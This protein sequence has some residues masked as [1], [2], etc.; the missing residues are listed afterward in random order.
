MSF[1]NKVAGRTL[2]STTSKTPPAW[3]RAQASMMR[4]NSHGSWPLTTRAAHHHPAGF[5]GDYLERQANPESPTS[6]LRL[7]HTQTG[8]CPAGRRRRGCPTAIRV[9]EATEQVAGETVGRLRP[10]GTEGH[11][12]RV[13]RNS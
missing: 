8:P 2:Q 6:A 12:P 10:R 4:N 5:T 1:E 9:T 13:L 11:P 3:C 7:R